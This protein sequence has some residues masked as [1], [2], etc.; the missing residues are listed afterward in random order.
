MSVIAIDPG[1]G[2]VDGEQVSGTQWPLGVPYWQTQLSEA[3]WAYD[4]AAEC[5]DRLD[6]VDDLHA[7]LTREE[8]EDAPSQRERGA[9][10][11]K[12]GADLVVSVHV[13]AYEDPTAKGA[14][15]FHWPGN[16]E[17]RTVAIE[18]LRHM[19]WALRRK[20]WV[21]DCDEAQNRNARAILAAHAP[22]TVLLE[23]GF[24]TN[25]EDREAMLDP[26]TKRLAVLATERAVLSWAA[27][28]RS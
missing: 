8:F 16:L 6:G 14:R 15:A 19:P 1:H 18:W 3:A 28:V 22:T 10:T 25:A 20:G 17:G 24:A 12:M 13:N 26:I 7:F 5:A 21:K 11:K 2:V 23:Y 9:R 27:R 4:V